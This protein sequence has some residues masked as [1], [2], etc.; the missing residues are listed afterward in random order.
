MKPQKRAGRQAAQRIRYSFLK[1]L[2]GSDLS[3][4]RLPIMVAESP[5]PGPL[6]W[7]TACGH[8]DEVGGIVVIQEIF[9]RL[10]K[11]PLVRG[12]VHAFPLMNPLGF[13]AISRTITL[14][15]EDLNRSFPGSA[16]GSLAERIAE[17]IFSAIIETRPALV[18]DLHN[19]WVHSIPY[20]LIDPDPGSS[21]KGPYKQARETA[22]ATGFVVI[23]DTDKLKTTLSYSLVQQD[24]PALTVELGAAYIVNEQNIAYGVESV[25]STLAQLG[26]TE[27]AAEPFRYPAPDVCVGRILDY[28]DKPLSSTSGI[29]RF[30]A[31]AGDLVEQGQPIAK[32]YNAFGK[33]LETIAAPKRALVLGHA[34]SAVAFPGV[35]V[36]AFGIVGD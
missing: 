1:I 25:W 28:S 8:G 9:K 4:R 21:H 14:S 7:L 11:R 12:A 16:G 3:R 15:K 5:T 23:C 35:P 26:L 36:I 33:L 32:V 31:K 13:E 6:V 17:R 20:T 10:R 30:L 19:D 34:D 27:P 2:T 24:V 29:I 22:A 18:L